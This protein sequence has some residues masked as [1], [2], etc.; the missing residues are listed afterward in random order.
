MIRRISEYIAFAALPMATLL[1]A[2]WFV[3]TNPFTF[4]GSSSSIVYMAVLVTLAFV[5]SVYAL[6]LAAAWISARA[7]ARELGDEVVGL[8]ERVEGLR[9]RDRKS[10]V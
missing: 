6:L 7:R 3:W 2:I 4:P 1:V 8:R 9:A 10:V 5:V